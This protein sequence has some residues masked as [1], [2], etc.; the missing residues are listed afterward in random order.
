MICVGIGQGEADHSARWFLLSQ[1]L[2]IEEAGV[3]IRQS[4]RWGQVVFNSSVPFDRLSTGRTEVNSRAS[5]LWLIAAGVFGSGV[6]LNLLAR[7]GD[8]VGNSVFGAALSALFVL[9]WLA[10]RIRWIGFEPILVIDRGQRTM[11]FL[12]AVMK[13][14][15]EHIVLRVAEHDLTAAYRLIQEWQAGKLI[16]E[17]E[18]NDLWKF[19]A[20]DA[21]GSGGYL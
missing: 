20:A 21:P 11:D 14:R 15:A 3:R 1:Q 16:T 18:A 8:W 2:W 10:G 6:I 5:M 17:Q 7:D 19:V 4:N 12:A 9:V 13:N